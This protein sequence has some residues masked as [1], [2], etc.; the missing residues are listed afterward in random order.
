MIETINSTI[1]GHDAE[2]PLHP[3]TEYVARLLIGDGNGWQDIQSV[4]LSLVEDFDDE[5]ASI[6]ANFTR[7]EDG[8]TMHLESGSTAVAVS[9]LYSSAS[10][11]PT[12][13]SILYLDIRFQL[14]WWFPEEFDTNGET[15]FVPIVKVIDWP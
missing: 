11:E 13:N 15:T 9:N 2:S 3:G 10:T 4:H 6:W 7:P 8:H 12:N 14:T 1:L 5:R